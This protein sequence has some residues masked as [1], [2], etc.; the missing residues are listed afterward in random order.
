LLSCSPSLGCQNK[1]K[2]KTESFIAFKLYPEFNSH[3]SCI[4]LSFHH[5]CPG[6]YTSLLRGSSS[7]TPYSV[8]S[9][10]KPVNFLEHKLDYFMS[11]LQTAVDLSHLSEQKL[12]SV[13]WSLAPNH[14]GFPR[15][16]LLTLFPLPHWVPAVTVL[17]PG[18]LFHFGQEVNSST[19][20]KHLS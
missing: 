7:L 16:Y 12:H 3:S 4:N 15:L 17:Q 5:L 20:F 14:H 6:P 18:M 13:Y 11:F 9:T 8:L 1:K 19:Y 2:E 10:E